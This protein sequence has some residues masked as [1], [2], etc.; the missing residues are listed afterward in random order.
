MA[1]RLNKLIAVTARYASRY[2]SRR[3]PVGAQIQNLHARDAVAIHAIDDERTAIVS[4]RLAG[5]GNVAE[6]LE[7][8]S[9]QRFKARVAGKLDDAKSIYQDIVTKYSKTDAFDEAQVR[10]AE[11]AR[12]Q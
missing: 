10:L 4:E 6:A 3:L 8:E 12:T 11:L 2:T 5:G 7:Q 9:G 1:R